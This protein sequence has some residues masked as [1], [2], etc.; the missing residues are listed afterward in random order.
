MAK[1][2]KATIPDTHV[3]RALMEEYREMLREAEQAAKKVL[4][5]DPHTEKFWDELTELAPQ[6]T[7]V[8]IRSNSIDEEILDLIDQLPED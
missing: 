3:L 7:W 2:K 6:I 4:G 1:N 8:G 5:L